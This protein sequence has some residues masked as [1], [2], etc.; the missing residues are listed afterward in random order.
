MFRA[1]REC[2]NK[3]Y[4]IQQQREK[5]EKSIQH[6]IEQL[7]QRQVDLDKQ[8]DIMQLK[9]KVILTARCII[10]IGHLL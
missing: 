5:T 2:A 8:M 6:E 1:E 3:L 10:H 4:S 7:M 9:F